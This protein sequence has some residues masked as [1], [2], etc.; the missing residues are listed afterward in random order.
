MS[1]DYIKNVW[2][3]K[4]TSVWLV[5]IRIIIGLEWFIAGIHKLVNP[6][7][8][9]GMYYLLT[10]VFGAD[11]NPHTW[12][13]YLLDNTFANNSELF[14]WLVSLGELFIGLTLIFGI[15]INFSAIVGFFLNL[16]FY[17][18]AGW[19]PTGASTKSLN[20]IM[21]VISCIFI[22]SVG[23]KNLSVDMYVAEKIPRLRR[24]LV[25]WFGFEKR[26]VI[27]K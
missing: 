3:H 5:I 7:Y 6:D 24:F 9:S 13:A 18:A 20:W 14:A 21:M 2:K 4:D 25:D 12:Y 1:L 19:T 15:F 23:V 22:L 11:A 26:E 17:F 27:N 16:N 10:E 8:V